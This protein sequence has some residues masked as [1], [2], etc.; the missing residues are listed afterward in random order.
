MNIASPTSVRAQNAFY[1]IGVHSNPL[2]FSIV[3]YKNKAQQSRLPPRRILKVLLMRFRLRN[4]KGVYQAS[5][6]TSLSKN[7]ST[8]RPYFKNEKEL[9]KPAFLTVHIN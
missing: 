3:F 9:A 1:P 8:A 4:T 7:K 5:T 6:A 2:V